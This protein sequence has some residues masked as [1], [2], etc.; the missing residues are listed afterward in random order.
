MGFIDE[1]YQIRNINNM[2]Q[3]S[4]CISNVERRINITIWNEQIDKLLPLIKLQAVISFEALC[5]SS[6][7]PLVLNV[8]LST[9]VNAIGIFPYNYRAR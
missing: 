7:L 1:I 3:L 5:C 2:Y 9:T 8:Q 4:F 6:T